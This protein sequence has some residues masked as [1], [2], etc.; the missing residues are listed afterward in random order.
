MH[1]DI[2]HVVLCLE[3][4]LHGEIQQNFKYN[5]QRV[6]QKVQL[7]VDN[8]YVALFTKQFLFTML[9]KSLY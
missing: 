1:F 7:K 3:T 9:V 5:L 2:Y 4:Y 8:N 6:Q